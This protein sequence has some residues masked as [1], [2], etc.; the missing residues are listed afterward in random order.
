MPINFF[1]QW[2]RIICIYYSSFDY[3]AMR[4]RCTYDVSLHSAAIST[5]MS[6]RCHQHPIE[7]GSHTL[8][9]SRSSECLC[10]IEC[11]SRA[12]S[13]FAF[14][15]IFRT[16]CLECGVA[17]VKFTL[18]IAFY[19]WPCHFR[20]NP[21]APYKTLGNWLSISSHSLRTIVAQCTCKSFETSITRF[22]HTLTFIY[23]F[24][25]RAM[26]FA[27]IF[28]FIELSVSDHRRDEYCMPFSVYISS[29]TLS[30]NENEFCGFALC[31]LFLLFYD[32]HL[33]GV[34]V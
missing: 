33:Y 17:R 32:S 16:F 21:I 10:F 7:K 22:V 8:I 2:N 19:R 1:M 5:N 30:T 13:V 15:C 18:M 4:F 12:R 23:C 11:N 25:E 14:V 6:S 29:I 24:S 20:A 34:I 28:A 26:Q 31:F 3:I 9:Y 27:L